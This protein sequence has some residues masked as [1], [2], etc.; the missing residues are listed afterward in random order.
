[1]A[2]TKSD[3]EALKRYWVVHHYAPPE[4]PDFFR[5]FT[6]IREM[7]YSLGK[8]MRGE[9]DAH[10]AWK[11]PFRIFYIYEMGQKAPGLTEVT[12]SMMI[13][14]PHTSWHQERE[15]EEPCGMPISQT[16]DPL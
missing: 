12:D 5:I 13:E 4:L 11:T 7:L 2:D 15:Y 6:D 9:L 8:H 16:G 10:V 14:A 3:F 1:M